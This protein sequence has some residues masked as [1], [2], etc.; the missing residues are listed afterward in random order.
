MALE[1]S[2][3]VFFHVFINRGMDAGGLL[4]KKIGNPNAIWTEAPPN[5]IILR[6]YIK[7]TVCKVCCPPSPYGLMCMCLCLHEGVM[8]GSCGVLV[9]KSVSVCVTLR[10]LHVFM[11]AWASAQ[12]PASFPLALLCDSFTYCV[13]MCMH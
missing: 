7:V 10:R 1:S 4:C 5:N 2:A 6:A 13:G 3:R 8:N 11:S 12:E 9:G